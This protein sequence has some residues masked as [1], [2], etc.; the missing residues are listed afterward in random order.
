M[1]RVDATRGQLSIALSED[2]LAS[3]EPAVPDLSGNQA[4]LGRELFSWFRHG[5]SEAEKGATLF[6]RDHND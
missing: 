6:F 4:G 3:R 5:A 1:I 2:E